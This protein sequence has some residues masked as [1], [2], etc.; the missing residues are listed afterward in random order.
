VVKEINPHS[1]LSKGGTLVEVSGAWFD[2]IPQYGVFPHCKFGDKIIRAKFI[3]TVRIVCVAPSSDQ[4]FVRFEVSLNGVDFTSTD[5]TFN[6][7]EEPIITSIYPFAGPESGGTEVRIRGTSFSN[8]TFSKEFQCRFTPLNSNI[9][10]KT[11][12]AKYEN[13]TSILCASPGGWGQGHQAAVQLTYNG[14]DYSQANDTFYFYNIMRAFPD[15][16]PADGRGGLITFQGTGFV[17]ATTIHCSLGKELALPYEVT[18]TEIKCPMKASTKGDS[19]FESV[20]LS[21]TINGKDWHD[22]RQGFQYYE[23]P[24]VEDIYPKTGP[25]IGKAIINFYGRNFRSDFKQAQLACKVGPGYG[26][27]EVLSPT[28]MRCRIRDV[29]L[30][31]PNQTYPV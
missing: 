30:L 6:Y 10:P 3:S 22:F 7:Y 13:D 31:G 20:E 29:P 5:S 15:S 21:V 17:N 25:N 16:G 8:N 9:R 2:Y 24:V 26:V 27:A 1:G 23:Q 4:Q 19:S 18:D 28:Q 11:I 14:Q 12:H